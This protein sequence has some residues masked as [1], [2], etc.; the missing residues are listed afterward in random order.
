MAVTSQPGY[1][2]APA[3]GLVATTQNFLTPSSYSYVAEFLGDQDPNLYPVYGNGLVT[4]FFEKMGAVRYTHSQVSRWAEETR[5]HALHTGVTRS[6]N[7][8][9]ITGG[10]FLRAGQNVII[11]DDTDMYIGHISAVVSSTVVTI[12]AY[13]ADSWNTLELGGAAATGTG[14]TISDLAGN[15]FLK[16][17]KGFDS[18][19]IPNQTI[20]TNTKRIVRG[21]D[22]MT[23]TDATEILWFN[24]PSGVLPNMPG[25][26]YWMFAHQKL[27][28]TRFLN[29]REA[30]GLLG[31]KA[32][33][34]SGVAGLGLG[35]MSGL[36]EQ[37]SDR[38]V[39]FTGNPT[40]IVGNEHTMTDWN[41]I[42]AILDQQGG[43]SN[44]ALFANTAFYG[45]FQATIKSQTEIGY[46]MFQNG[47]NMAYSMD[48]R[49]FDL[50]GYSF[51]ITKSKFLNDGAGM[52]AMKGTGKVNA[53]AIPVGNTT[54]Y[55]DDNTVSV[56]FV[57]VDTTRG[58]KG[59]DR[60]LQVNPN[61]ADPDE[62]SYK[63]D[64]LSEFCIKAVGANNGVIFK[65]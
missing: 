28:F 45:D 14:I 22:K 42:L 15:D 43:N 1:G 38:G 11:S 59:E 5:V 52:G 12:L 30:T 25:G 23:K 49:G 8:F 47:K 61:A 60:Y 36:F 33:A 41:T 19:L 6:A 40:G 4:G 64:Y 48:F 9:T 58:A 3:K 26:N 55:E 29:D 57:H 20:R 63:F 2:A 16:G 51:Y 7:N 62:D 37:I 54:V 56:P 53:F 44:Y 17:S 24:I 18:G 65:S 32:E 34:G 31:T 39:D 27:G 21:I 13:S 35:N 50:S 46:G 10:H